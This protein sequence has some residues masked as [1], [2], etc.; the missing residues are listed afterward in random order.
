MDFFMKVINSDDS[1][2]FFT[3]NIDSLHDMIVEDPE[4]VD[5]WETDHPEAPPFEFKL[6]LP[7]Q[8]SIRA[9]GCGNL[10]TSRHGID[11]SNKAGT[12]NLDQPLQVYID[13]GRHGIQSPKPSEQLQCNMSSALGMPLKVY[14]L[15]N[16][17]SSAFQNSDSESTRD[18]ILSTW[19]SFHSSTESDGKGA[20]DVE[21]MENLLTCS[22]LVSHSGSVGH[23]ELCSRPCLYY[24]A[25][26]CVNGNACR[27]CHEP[28]PDRAHHLDKHHRQMLKAMPFSTSL[29]LMSPI[30]KTKAAALD[31]PAEFV[32]QL[33][34]SLEV[35]SIVENKYEVETEEA[36]IK[37]HIAQSFT[38]A[39]R[40]MSLRSMLATLTRKAKN[41]HTQE[42]IEKVLQ[43]MREGSLSQ[44]LD[45]HG[46]ID[47]QDSDMLVS[48]F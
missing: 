19:G 41:Q 10:G 43:A 39:F 20:E 31:L 7:D 2:D 29:H 4:G 33:L 44:S 30:I 1:M 32:A 17:K 48:A 16:I 14:P 13:G 34:D 5:P 21:G 40:L 46:T 28:H 24:A 36:A 27:F 26:K 42:A 9:D 15:L 47:A 38:R 22:R 35:A 8:E 6:L 25:G 18:S 3:G 45:Q 37:T 12:G 11:A 23:P